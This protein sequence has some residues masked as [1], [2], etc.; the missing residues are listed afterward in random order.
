[1]YLYFSAR[2][3][4]IVDL[5][6]GVSVDTEYGFKLGSNKGTVGNNVSQDRTYMPTSPCYFWLSIFPSLLCVCLDSR[7]FSLVPR[8][9]STAGLA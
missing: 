1:M 5:S 8:Y 7:G 3:N 2:Y 4:S 6:I 9:M